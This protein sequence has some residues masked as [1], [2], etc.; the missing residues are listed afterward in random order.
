MKERLSTFWSRGGIFV[1][2]LGVALVPSITTWGLQE[3]TSKEDSAEMQTLTD[4]AILTTTL[5]P[6]PEGIAPL[7]GIQ[8]N[9]DYGKL[10]K[11]GYIYSSTGV[12]RVSDPNATRGWPA[13]LR[14]NDPSA[15]PEGLDHPHHPRRA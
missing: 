6:R 7:D 14:A 5:Y 2:I 4:G 9:T 8:E 15:L 10:R 11:S 3:R 1:L 12:F 13:E